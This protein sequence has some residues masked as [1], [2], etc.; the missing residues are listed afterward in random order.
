LCS[1]LLAWG[2]LG[3]CLPGRLAAQNPA[4]MPLDGSPA[5]LGPYGPGANIPSS[6]N[7]PTFNSRPASWPG[8][9]P[10]EKPREPIY[11]ARSE[12]RPAAPAGSLRI[13]APATAP[14]VGQ[15]RKIG[16]Y[17]GAEV[18]ARIASE[19]VLASEIIPGVNDLMTRHIADIPP[20][21]VDMTR[22]FLIRTR[23]MDAVKT[24]LL[25]AEARK[26]IP[27][28]N[29][30]KLEKKVNEQFDKTQL[31]K[32]M[33]GLKVSSRAELEARLRKEGTSLEWQR[34]AFF[35]RSLASQWIH[36]QIKEDEEISHEELLVYY[37]EHVAE[38]E[39]VARARW[40]EL[41]VRFT[42]YNSKADAY[43]ALAQWGNQL[44]TGA[45]FAELAKAHSDDL[46]AEVGGVHEWTNKGSLASVV[47]DDALFGMPVG[48]LSPIIEDN[49][50]FHII[51]VLERNPLTRKPFTEAQSEIKK[52]LRDERQSSQMKA[53]L[54]KLT[55]K[56]PVWTIF[57][58]PSTP[59][60]PVPIDPDK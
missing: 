59:Q 4:Q 21:Q 20:E 48:Q 34:K 41:M 19:V 24:K 8:A 32:L 30:P 46:T 17:D 56:T 12:P 9:A 33:E 55:A 28:D 43:R 14:P 3:A 42:S 35:E 47:L 60:V 6:P 29:L 50:G 27:A 15:P 45:P 37:R 44:Q 23:L 39:T 5:T 51:R 1:A 52:R 18:L 57:D 53:Y 16:Q 58:D 40:E 10:A 11:Q 54:A 22:L 7:K 36:Q 2:V 31:T 49:V 38:Y 13:S 26:S 25:V